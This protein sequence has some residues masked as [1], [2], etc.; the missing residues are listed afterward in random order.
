MKS[1]LFIIF[2]ADLHNR[3]SRWFFETHVEI[4]I[5]FEEHNEKYLVVFGEWLFT[6]HFWEVVKLLMFRNVA[7]SLIRFIKNCE[8]CSLYWSTK[9]KF[10]ASCQRESTR[11]ENSLEFARLL[12]PPFTSYVYQMK[13][14]F[15][16]IWT[17]FF[18]IVVLFWPITYARDLSQMRRALHGPLL[19]VFTKRYPRFEED[20]RKHRTVFWQGIGSSIKELSK[21][22]LMNFFGS[23]CYNQVSLDKCS[24]ISMAQICCIYDVYL[25]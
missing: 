4:Y 7:S 10:Y 8:L 19:P 17:F 24:D 18:V 23:E 15:L 12:H 11:L 6:I 16:S 3:R 20:Q 9:I 14:T 13:I 1:R 2:V 25:D 22:R 21:N 5:F